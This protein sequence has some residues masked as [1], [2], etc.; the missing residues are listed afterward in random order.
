MLVKNFIKKR[1]RFLKKPIRRLSHK[2]NYFLGNF[3]E[4]V[5]LIGD[6]RSGTTWVSDLINHEKK[7]WEM[8]EPFH[9]L[10]NGKNLVAPHQ[11]LRPDTINKKFEDFASDI[12]KGRLINKRYDYV[13]KSFFYKGLL[14]KD[15]FANL[16]VRWVSVRFPDI[17][18]ILLIRN[19]F[20]VA[21]SKYKK[22]EWFWGTEPLNLFNQADLYEDYLS[23]FEDIIKKTSAEKDFILCQ[24][25]I[26]CIINYV[27]LLQFKP[28][29][30]HIVFYEDIYS[31]TNE[32]I[33]EIYNFIKIEPLDFRIKIDR[34]KIMEPSRV[35]GK[36]SNIL[37]GTSPIVSWKDEI[38]SQKID[39]GFEILNCFGFEELY[40]NESM[41]NWQV[42]KKIHEKS[43]P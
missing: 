8:F 22:Q 28:G 21:L 38:S 43:D 7:Y 40:N 41:P 42:L 11:Y 26:W 1:F 37:S 24:I 36:E 32:I 4:V 35:V 10:Y 18:I 13:N 9:P 3:K 20:S 19:P 16:F 6:G 39:A 30:I 29:Q 15:I 23:P 12:F 14:I 17:R 34:K 5:W 27:P 33:R 25:L 2:S 31:K